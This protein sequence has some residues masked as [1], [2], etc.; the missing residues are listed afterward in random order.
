MR[1]FAAITL[2]LLISTASAAG[3]FDGNWDLEKAYCAEGVSSDTRQRISGNVS[4]RY[5][6][7][8]ELLNPTPIRGM[9]NTV[10]YDR[11]CVSEGESVDGGR[12]LMSITEDGKL[13]TYNQGYLDLRIKC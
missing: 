10:L 2:S 13:M 11:K 6:S 3:P 5:E 12:V 9:R 4:Y 8:C 7:S 1:I